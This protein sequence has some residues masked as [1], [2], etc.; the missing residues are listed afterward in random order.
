MLYEADAARLR[1]VI[2]L[3][4]KPAALPKAKDARSP[5]FGKPCSLYPAALQIGLAG[6]AND[7][8][9]AACL[10]HDVSWRAHP[11]YRAEVLL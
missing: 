10:L 11:D 4:S 5:G 2:P 1:D 3:D 6:S 9:K 8:F 7:W